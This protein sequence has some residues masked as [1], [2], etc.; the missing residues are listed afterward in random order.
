M[1]K[2]V[3]LTTLISLL[4][5]ACAVDII[6]VTGSVSGVVKD[7]LTGQTI[8]NCQVT[9][10]SVGTTVFTNANGG[11]SF[12]D[13]QPNV[14]TLTYS[15]IGYMDQTASVE[16]VAGQNVVKD[17]MLE[18]VEEFT[19]SHSVLDFGDISS[20]LSFSLQNPTAGKYDF[21][22]ANDIPWLSFSQT[23]GT[24]QANN[25]LNITASVDRSLVGYG[26]YDKTFTISYNG[27]TS[28]NVVVRAVMNKVQ[29]AA[30]TVET[31]DPTDITANSF[32][33]GGY[34]TSTGGEM[35]TEYGHCWSY[36]PNPT[37]DSEH[38]SLGKTTENIRYTSKIY[39]SLVN[40]TVYVR[41]YAK[42]S[43]G[44]SY[45]QEVRVTSQSED[46]S[47]DGEFAG[48]TGTAYDPYQIRKAAHMLKMRD[49]PE[50]HFK[51]V[52][53]IDMEGSLWTP[54]PMN[55][56]FDGNNYTIYNLTINPYIT[57][58][59][60]GLFSTVYKGDVKNLT[61]HNVSANFPN[62]SY[63]GS[64]AGYVDQATITNSHV[65]LTQA[66]SIIGKDYVGGL[67]GYAQGGGNY[68]NGTTII[69][70]CTVSSTTNSV[71]IIG[72]N[73]VGGAIGSIS[74]LG[75]STV[76]DIL[77]NTC[78]AGIVGVGGIAGCV[79]S[80]THNRHVLEQ[81]SFEGTITALTTDGR[82]V[83]GLVG[84]L[85]SYN[86]IS[87]S[88]ANAIIEGNP[89][90]A[91]G[92]VGYDHVACS[93]IIACY[94][95]GQI[96]GNNNGNGIVGSSYRAKNIKYCYTLYN[97]TIPSYWGESFSIYDLVSQFNSPINIAEIMRANCST[98]ASQYWDFD[99][100][101]T[102]K[103]TANG[104]SVTAICPK[105]KWEK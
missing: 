10:S 2:G 22:I 94:S 53:D 39:C 102:W 32:S 65:V 68:N 63:I 93:S 5:C 69:S 79:S 51:L 24:I 85:C 31:L 59:K 105:L 20:T 23:N 38:S 75:T 83:G 40:K 34:I 13:L 36:N 44:I 104:Q 16:V 1:K 47:E 84:E 88:K 25:K 81:L 7:Y 92:L 76:S 67:V 90:N 95:Q 3:I 100:T 70:S 61:L 33:I 46:S 26:S 74:D 66:N 80:G 11:Y 4:F 48:G 45:G 55:T 42:N 77:V 99:R 35:V 87:S 8:E 62:R 6:D 37:T 64:I 56:S 72:S 19:V 30:P 86:V 28:G 29:Q 78:I 18:S 12:T 52:E 89:R 21:T 27:A 50:A 49:Y 71:T 82:D 41:A 43:K 54:I 58:D 14:Y 73:H 101:W 17:I 96:V 60:I 97:S 57:T 9:L 91:G 15:K 98:E 103:G